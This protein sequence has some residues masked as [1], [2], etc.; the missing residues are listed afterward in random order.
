MTTGRINQVT[1]LNGV[2]RRVPRY[3]LTR[4]EQFTVALSGQ[5]P[6]P[7]LGPEG[8]QRHGVPLRTPQRRV[9]WSYAATPNSNRDPIAPTEFPT[10]WSVAQVLLQCD[11]Q[12]AGG[13]YR[14]PVTSEDGYRLRL[15]PEC[16]GIRVDHRSVIHRLQQS[17]LVAKQVVGH[18]HRLPSVTS[19]VTASAEC[20]PRGAVELGPVFSHWQDRPFL[21]SARLWYRRCL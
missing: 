13:G 16:L 20:L 6:T 12:P 4:A 7:L 5:R 18:F 14:S 10:G 1:I 2:P 15:T 21:G 11:M 9:L 17:L 19:V 8:R 3:P